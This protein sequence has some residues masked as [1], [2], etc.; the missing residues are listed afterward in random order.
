M[1]GQETRAATEARRAGSPARIL[2]AD[3]TDSNLVALEIA[4]E[5][6]GEPL[7]RARSG[8]QALELLKREEFALALVDVRMPDLDGFEVLRRIRS[9]ER[10]KALPVIL[11]SAFE[12]GRNELEAA[13]E[14]GAADY[15]VKPFAPSV[16]RTKAQLFVDLYHSQRDLERRVEE[17]TAALRESEARLRLLAH[18]LPA[19][20]WTTDSSLRF[21]MLAGKVISDLGLEPST[22]VGRRLADSVPAGDPSLAAHRRALEGISGSYHGTYSGRR[23]ESYVEP[24]RDSS[25]RVQGVVGV[26]FDRTERHAAEDVHA[27]LSAIVDSSDDAIISKTLD[28][29]VTSWNAGAERIFGYSSQEMVER[30]IT[31]LIPEDRLYEERDIIEKVSRGERID[32]F[33]TVRR[34]KDGTLIDVSVTISPLR[35][36]EG[37]VVGASKIAR[38]VTHRKRTEEEIRR[39]NQDLERRVLE[40]TSALR[41]MLHE[42][43]TFAYTVAHDLRGP[44]RAIQ[45]FSTLLLEEL[46][47]GRLEEARKLA[48]RIA[49]GSERMEALIRDILAYSRLS[50]EEVSL[51]PLETG[52][53]VLDIVRE[54]AE[55]ISSKAADVRAKGPFP[56]AIGSDMLLRQALTNLLT[57][58]L[59]FARTGQS[60]RVRI[61]AEHRQEG[62]VRVWVE[63]D[64]IGIA[65]QH[66]RK[67]FQVFAR[68]HAGDKYP[69][70][71]IGLAIVRRAMERMNGGCGVLSEEGVG[72]RFWIEL[73]AATVPKGGDP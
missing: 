37:R 58:A 12:P 49:A 67:L 65:P 62:R 23:F 11:I 13:Y 44:A 50:R 41:E 14:S 52:A 46:V 28:G 10:L 2:I 26:G 48:A 35:N 54:H 31:T 8:G 72:S 64:G 9:A 33:E 57:N 70:T 53:I 40:R 3:D 61:R 1:E 55:E 19:V 47:P 73:P 69:G 30:P 63:D 32:H 60:P 71:G 45:G 22:L 38:D 42:L 66:Q 5:H 21:T 59:K 36:S 27:R 17:R 68:L 4:L 18:Q 56:W 24:L 6:L 51:V 7:V 16:I 25:G 15:V 29:I 34:R 43:D 20:Q 39:L